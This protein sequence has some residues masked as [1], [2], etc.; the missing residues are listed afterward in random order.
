MSE[1]R[2]DIL[3]LRPVVVDLALEAALLRMLWPGCMARL[4]GFNPRQQLGWLGPHT[5][6]SWVHG[7]SVALGMHNARDGIPRTEKCLECHLGTKNKFVDHEMVAAVRP[8][9]FLQ[10]DT[11]SGASPP[12]FRIVPPSSE[13]QPAREFHAGG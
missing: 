11:F 7:K 4:A 1:M 3:A 5:T 9:F 8:R 13:A 10:L 12:K 2:R 6:R